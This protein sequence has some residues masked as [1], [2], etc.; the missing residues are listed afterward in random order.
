M[1]HEFSDVGKEVIMSLAVAEYAL[2]QMTEEG[3]EIGFVKSLQYWSLLVMG[4]YGVL[5]RFR[6]I[7]C[8]PRIPTH[9]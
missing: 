7:C 8:G 9:T 6:M 5:D 4:G 3:T 1:I 2:A